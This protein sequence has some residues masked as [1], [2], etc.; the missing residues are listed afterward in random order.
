MKA[1]LTK[2][3]FSP[4]LTV[5]RNPALMPVKTVLAGARLG[6]TEKLVP[7]KGI[8]SA[9]MPVEREGYIKCKKHDF[10]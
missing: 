7:V 5:I 3:H 8:V 1:K 6:W 10:L 9:R 4:Q 2:E